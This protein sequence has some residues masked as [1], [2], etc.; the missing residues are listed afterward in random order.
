MNILTSMIDLISLLY[1]YSDVLALV[2]CPRPAAQRSWLI[3]DVSVITFWLPWTSR[4]VLTSWISY[5]LNTSVLN[6]TIMVKS[7][8]CH[9]VV[10]IE[11]NKQE[12]AFIHSALMCHEEGGLKKVDCNVVIHRTNN[13][14]K[15]F[16]EST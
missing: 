5:L 16:T 8:R 1:F 13:I 9:H 2:S 14:P 10:D 4:V 7:T 12:V 6:S 3:T 15:T 11:Y